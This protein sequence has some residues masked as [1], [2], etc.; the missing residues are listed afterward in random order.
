MH[1]YLQHG[2]LWWCSAGYA[3]QPALTSA[4]GLLG[5]QLLPARL[6]GSHAWLQIP[7]RSGPWL[8]PAPALSALP[9]R[10]TPLISL[11]VIR[12]TYLRPIFFMALHGILM[13]FHPLMVCWK[14]LPPCQAVTVHAIVPNAP[15]QKVRGESCS[16]ENTLSVVA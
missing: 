6:P 15:H 11:Q 9:S 3:R 2:G 13:K 8:A 4:T 14:V 10:A 5:L 1:A 16:R 7:P 12:Y